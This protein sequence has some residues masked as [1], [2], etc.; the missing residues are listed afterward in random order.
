M[1]LEHLDQAILDP[2]RSFEARLAQLCRRTGFDHASY[3]HVNRDAG[4]VSGFTIYPAHWVSVYISLN[5]CGKDP[6]LRA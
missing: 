1:L 2:T 3:A 5:L 6:V 4:I